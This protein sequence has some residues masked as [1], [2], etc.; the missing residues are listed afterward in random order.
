MDGLAGLALLSA[1]WLMLAVVAIRAARPAER[2][3]E[4]SATPDEPPATMLTML[5]PRTAETAEPV[6]AP[7]PPPE[8]GPGETEE[9][10][11]IRSLEVAEADNDAVRLTQDGVA[12]ARLLIGR[13]G[14]T[15]AKA[16]LTKTVIVA[17]RGK[18]APEHAAARIELADIA[19][20]E[21]D[22][23][24]A[25][26]HWQLAK[27]LFHDLDRKA[28]AQKM[29]DNLRLNRCPTDWFLTQF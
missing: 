21:G 28:D 6:A 10:R 26:E 13:G 18:L 1:P 14:Q 22:M 27:Q 17:M 9:Q 16:L 3:D 24:T 15:E 5:G 8:T 12:L 19:R 4:P 2:R 7:L 20:H 25:C 11:L 29:G 23:T